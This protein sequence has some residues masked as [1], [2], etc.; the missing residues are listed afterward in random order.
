Q[1]TFLVGPQDF[2]RESRKYL[3]VFGQIDIIKEQALGDMIRTGDI[4]RYRRRALRIYHTR[5]DYFAGLLQKHV[6]DFV[7]FNLP[8]GGKAFWIRFKK[9][10]NL[11]RF[12]K[13][14]KK[15]GLFLP[16][17]CLFQTKE[18]CAIRLGFGHLNEKEMVEVIQ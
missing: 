1:T 18:T 8:A 11:V 9:P 13:E 2:I 16:G 4:H 10:I 7:E 5:R 3:N 17:T 12:S 6:S 15:G 14:L